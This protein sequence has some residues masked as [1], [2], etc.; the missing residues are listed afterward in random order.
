MGRDVMAMGR[1]VMCG[2]GL[3]AHST[4]NTSPSDTVATGGISGCHRLWSG[5]LCSQGM[6]FGSTESRFVTPLIGFTSSL[7]FSVLAFLEAG[8]MLLQCRRVRTRPPLI[9]YATS[10]MA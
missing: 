1:D 9:S 4:R 2:D 3:A 7:P 6:S 8:A 10:L 5:G